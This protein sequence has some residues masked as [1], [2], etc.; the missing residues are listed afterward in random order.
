MRRRWSSTEYP[1]SLE[2][3]PDRTWAFQTSVLRSKLGWI[4]YELM[5][6]GWHYRREA[7]DEGIVGEG[8]R[9]VIQVARDSAAAGDVLDMTKEALSSHW[10]NEVS[11]T[12]IREQLD[13]A[14]R[15]RSEGKL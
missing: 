6:D 7:S 2:N 10:I 12:A 1:F 14:K 13:A 4:E 5:P 15:A 8:K 3:D 9:T 11:R